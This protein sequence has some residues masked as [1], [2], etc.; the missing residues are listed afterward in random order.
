MHATTAV[1]RED[2]AGDVVRAG[3]H[4]HHRLGDLIGTGVPIEGEAGV[5]YVMRAGFD[6][7][8][9]MFTPE[10]LEALYVGMA[11]LHRTGDP[12]LE[13]A[14]RRAGEKIASALPGDAPDVPLRASGW[15]RIPD[16]GPRPE[17]LRED[18]RK[19][20]V[21]Q[22]D[23]RDEDGRE[24]QR[25]IK[26][27]ALIYYIDAVVLAAWCGLRRGFRHFRIDRIARCAATGESFAPE[28]GRL[29]KA[30]EAT[31]KPG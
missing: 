20:Q 30:W 14:A 17:V 24:T 21:L 8:P 26:P 23:Y 7:P 13:R 29:R 31:A 6:L 18:I 11:L 22:I 9:L 12:G 4:T 27:L 2:L 3:Y 19:A 10:E 28:A 1:Y 25:E 16:A 5:G 15:H